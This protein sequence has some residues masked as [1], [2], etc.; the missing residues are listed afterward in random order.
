MHIVFEIRHFLVM[1]VV[2]ILQRQGQRKQKTAC[3]EY[4]N[5]YKGEE[6]NKSKIS[7]NNCLD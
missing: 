5:W 4:R 2:N 6:E 7:R 1:L 3:W